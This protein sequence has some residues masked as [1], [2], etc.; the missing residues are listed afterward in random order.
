M[1]VVRPPRRSCPRCGS[2]DD[3]PHGSRSECLTANAKE[4]RRLLKRSRFLLEKRL[5]LSDDVTTESAL[6]R[7]QRQRLRRTEVE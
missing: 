2:Q 4:T 7:E 6:R 5:K 3:L 1:V